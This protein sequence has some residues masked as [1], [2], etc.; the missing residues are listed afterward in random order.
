MW[1]ARESRRFRTR[2]M[3]ALARLLHNHVVCMRGRSPIPRTRERKPDWRVTSP[4]RADDDDAH[5]VTA[6]T[7]GMGRRVTADAVRCDKAYRPSCIPW[8]RSA[9]ELDV[10]AVLVDVLRMQHVARD[11]LPASAA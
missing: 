5:V 10:I 11:R 9:C 7:P 4:D 6:E 2:I 8:C 3:R 1:S